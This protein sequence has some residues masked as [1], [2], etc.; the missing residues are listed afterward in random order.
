MRPVSWT[1]PLA[2]RKKGQK[3]KKRAKA[4][5]AQEVHSPETKGMRSDEDDG[6]DD[7]DKTSDMSGTGFVDMEI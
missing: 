4:T 3:F 2:S 5:L 1:W 6:D 7:S